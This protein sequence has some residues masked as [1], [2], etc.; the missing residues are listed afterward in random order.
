MSM[1]QIFAIDIATMLALKWILHRA[2]IV[3]QQLTR[4]AL[5]QKKHRSSHTLAQSDSVIFHIATI[6]Q[7]EPHL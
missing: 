1:H 2:H 5:L 6:S 4:P 7:L 3:F